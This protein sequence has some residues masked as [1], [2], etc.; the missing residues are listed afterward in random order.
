MVRLDPDKVTPL[1]TEAD[2]RAD[3]AR[4]ITKP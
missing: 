2:S 3:L 4:D 1:K